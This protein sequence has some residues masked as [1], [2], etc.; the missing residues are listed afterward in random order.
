MKKIL[1]L[2]SSAIIALFL[3]SGC[4]TKL[5]E[6]VTQEEIPRE[7]SDQQYEDENS[8]YEN[9]VFEAPDI[10]D[11]NQGYRDASRDF[12]NSNLWYG[13]NPYSRF[14]GYN[15]YWYSPW[16]SYYSC[17]LGYYDPFF[18]DPFFD[19]GYYSYGYYN[20]YW[21]R[22]FGGYYYPYSRYYYSHGYYPYGGYY[23]RGY[24]SREPV[25]EGRQ[26]KKADWQPKDSSTG[27]KRATLT[28]RV[29]NPDFQSS[30]D[31]PMSAGSG[32]AGNIG[33]S[34]SRNDNSAPIVSKPRTSERPREV[35][36]EKQSKKQLN[37]KPRDKSI[38][39]FQNMIRPP[40]PKSETKIIRR[41][42]PSRPSST[43][44]LTPP[45]KKPS[46]R[47]RSKPK[48]QNSNEHKETYSAPKR[49]SPARS[50][51]IR[52]SRSS[53]SSSYKAPSRSGSARSST[54]RS[55][56]VSPK[57]S[58]RSSSVRSSSSSRSSGRS[59]SIRSSSGSKS[60]SS[61]SSRSSSS[62]K[63]SSSKSSSKSSKNSRNR[64]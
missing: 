36:E 8:S 4:Y 52:S 22:N 15:S 31:L 26:Q 6:P 9:Y 59:S 28:P 50:S 62:G 33:S 56:S 42:A 49:K 64:N 41:S 46:V 48:M 13:Y 25:S 37:P 3:L 12:L 21:Y 34:G 57:P 7:D 61:S 43:P 30:L 17:Y 47:Q 55:S 44:D 5:S 19:W 27:Q 20:P 11:Y 60:S 18:Y 10:S 24:G 2:L 53:K 63:S 14:Y 35:L 38:P 29:S 54:P 39:G 40:K 23:H 58:S 32:S 1:K 51:S 16:S 45:K